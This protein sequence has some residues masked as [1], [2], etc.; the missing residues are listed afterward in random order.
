MIESIQK[1]V[2][3]LIAQVLRRDELSITSAS[4]FAEDLGADSLSI[5]ELACLVEDE[6]GIAMANG[7]VPNLQTVADVV[8][9]LQLQAARR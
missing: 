4:R 2:I 7:R 3:K 9:A 6:F 1:R 8:S 5:V